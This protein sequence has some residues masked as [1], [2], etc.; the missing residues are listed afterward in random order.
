MPDFKVL[1][2]KDAKNVEQIEDY[3]FRRLWALEA[4]DAHAL[5]H[6]DLQY[7]VETGRADEDVYKVLGE[8]PVAWQPFLDKSKAARHE[9]GDQTLWSQVYPPKEKP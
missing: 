8:K 7:L 4:R 3:W 6:T 1:L 2:H 9:D 5:A